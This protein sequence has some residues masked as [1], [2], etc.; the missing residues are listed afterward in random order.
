MQHAALDVKDLA[1]RSRK[2][3]VLSGINFAV[4]PGELV[5]VFGPLGCGK[6]SLLGAL[7]GLSQS[8]GSI[9]LFGDSV[10][11][12]I[13]RIELT[14]QPGAARGATIQQWL[15]KRAASSRVPLAQRAGRVAR[16][17][18]SMELFTF[19][20][21]AIRELSNGQQRSVSLAGGLASRSPVLLIDA[22]LD[23]LSEPLL[24]RT[25]NHLRGRVEK[26]NAAVIF[27]TV[28]SEIAERA[29]RVLIVDSGRS[30]TF[31]P[32]A[33]ILKAYGQDTIT[34]EAVD[35]S[36]VRGTLRGVSEV[37][38]E[39]TPS[40]LMFTATDGARAAASLFRHPPQGV[41]A[42]YVRRPSLWDALDRL[43]EESQS[44]TAHT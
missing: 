43:R 7:A 12:S 5:A 24:E 1:V 19:R 21:T 29:D 32:P 14:P 39:E 27:A 26:E 42:I 18:D 44:E 22:L 25:W 38:M 41:R 35:P 10:S 20:D 3:I 17:L 15:M 31:S 30:L 2:G 23:A 6:S 13:A 34:I 33:E 16:A 40:G 9:R 4:Q 8:E 37:E 36:L 28:R 11:R